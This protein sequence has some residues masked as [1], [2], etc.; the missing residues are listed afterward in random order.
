MGLKV[1][2]TGRGAL[3]HCDVQNGHEL[4]FMRFAKMEEEIVSIEKY[5]FV[6][7]HRT[8]PETDEALAKWLGSEEWKN[9]VVLFSG[10]PISNEAGRY[11]LPKIPHRLTR[12]SII[13]LYWQNVPSDFSGTA[14]ELVKLL[15]G[16]EWDIVA[17]LAILCQGYLVFRSLAFEEVSEKT[18]SALEQ[19]GWSEAIEGSVRMKARDVDLSNSRRKPEEDPFKSEW[20]LGALQQQEAVIKESISKEWGVKEFSQCA[21]ELRTL[22]AEIYSRSEVQE[23]TVADA[24]CIIARKLGGQPCP[25]PA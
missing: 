18:R 5:N 9:R 20:W 23:E 21:E 10:G 19:L 24:Y 22:I 6:F 17:A 16:E 13:D 2:V 8:N 4:V 7:Q 11:D 15:V 14:A 1:L 3:D 12:Q 25:S